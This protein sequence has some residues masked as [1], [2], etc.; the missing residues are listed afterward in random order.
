MDF[1]D[2]KIDEYVVKHTS[3]EPKLLYQL[4]R[5]TYMKVLQPRMLSGHLQG[6]VLSM[7]SKMIRPKRVLEIGTYTGYSAICLAEGL[8]EN[9]QLHTIDKNEEQEGF[10]QGF[11]DKA[12][13]SDKIFQHIGNALEII[14]KLKEDWDIVFIDADKE[15]YINY[16]NLVIPSLKSG[17]YVI[18]D[19]VLW[20]GKV[21]DDYDNLDEETKVLVDY[22]KFI[23]EDER[24][25]NVLFPIRDGL[26]IA[27]VK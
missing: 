27:R 21:L 4:N 26:N 9:G 6:R 8:V 2:E 1:I 12:D 23:Q 16:Y 3:K 18:A 17:A 11:I 5:E 13:F 10:V 7:L 25:E 19:N 15:N 20:S 14:P 22:S 24:V